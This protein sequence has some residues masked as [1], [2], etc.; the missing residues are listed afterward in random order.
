MTVKNK[1]SAAVQQTTAPVQLNAIV[2]LQMNREVA[3]GDAAIIE[4]EGFNTLLT[5]HTNGHTRWTVIQPKNQNPRI[6][7]TL[8]PCTQVLRDRG[9]D[10]TFVGIEELTGDTLLQPIVQ[11]LHEIAQHSHVLICTRSLV[12]E[13]LVAAI[14]GQVYSLKNPPRF[15]IVTVHKNGGNADVLTPQTA[16]VY[17]KATAG[18]RGTSEP[19]PNQ[20]VVLRLIST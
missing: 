2:V 18:K 11:H 10:V 1:K 12:R 13:R 17:M 20:R 5:E 7:K 15:P 19:D 3:D 4:H 14:L 16:T 8:D 6:N 9:C